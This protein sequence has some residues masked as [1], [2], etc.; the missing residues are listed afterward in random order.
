MEIN[1]AFTSVFQIEN[2]RLLVSCKT[3]F[4]ACNKHLEKR[5]RIETI[6]ERMGSFHELARKVVHINLHTCTIFLLVTLKDAFLSTACGLKS[7]KT[8]FRN[9]ASP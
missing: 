3:N 6:R 1:W 8:C 7:L 2:C 9:L 5:I 4:K